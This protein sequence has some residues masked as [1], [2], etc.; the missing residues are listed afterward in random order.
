L[1]DFGSAYSPESQTLLKLAYEKE[2]LELYI[3]KAINLNVKP[4]TVYAVLTLLYDKDSCKKTKNID[5]DTSQVFQKKTKEF[6][7]NSNVS[8]PL[9]S[10]P[11]SVKRMKYFAI[12]VLSH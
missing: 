10:K 7:A 12:L 5:L 9:F 1:V 4:G 6:G 2:M 11:L 8:N 3:K